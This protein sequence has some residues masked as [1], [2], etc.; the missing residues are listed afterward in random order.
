MYASGQ[1][2]LSKVAGVGKNTTTLA[3]L[4]ALAILAGCVRSPETPEIP[5]LAPAAPTLPTLVDEYFCPGGQSSN[6]TPCPGNYADPTVLQFIWGAQLSP[7]GQNMA[8]LVTQVSSS[9]YGGMPRANPS[10]PGTDF[11]RL[12]VLTSRDAGSTW[13]SN[14]VPA[15][16]LNTQLG[17]GVPAGVHDQN[18]PGGMVLDDQGI[19]HVVGL[20]LVDLGLS[21][22]GP[23]GA[24]F[25]AASSDWGASWEPLD[26]IAIHGDGPIEQPSLV[27]MANGTL[28]VGWLDDQGPHVSL[29]HDD[30]RTWSEAAMPSPMAACDRAPALAA[31]G[32]HII[33]A[34]WSTDG[35]DTGGP[36]RI[37]HLDA[38]TGLVQNTTSPRDQPMGD[39]AC[40]QYAI[41]G[42][43]QEGV[44]LLGLEC[45]PASYLYL[46]PDSATTWSPAWPLSALG[47]PQ[48]PEGRF[49]A[50][51]A[52]GWGRLHLVLDYLDGPRPTPV[53]AGSHVV[54]RV[55]DPFDARFVSERDLIGPGSRLQQCDLGL[56]G[57]GG[58]IGF[59][60]GSGL[61]A[62]GCDAVGFAL[63][64]THEQG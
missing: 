45:G 38:A 61:L 4:M 20:H 51:A 57:S 58:A 32:Q 37:Y 23:A 40:K 15:E 46:S 42:Y 11:S 48:A 52:D 59:Y 9:L 60:S 6:A 26:V 3:L 28:A 24:I 8:I 12:A 18:L 62:F 30:G 47:P 33:F 13:Q 17:T 2:P 63:Q 44:A 1:I 27:R 43:G 64:R 19:L 14:V 39:R 41:T 31:T 29:S 10:H 54:H 21:G 36:A 34:C 53:L 5:E 56:L 22:L 7:D 16:T 55:I 50:M 49:L 35:I 25:H